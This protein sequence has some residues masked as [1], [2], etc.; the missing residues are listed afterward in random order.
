[1]MHLTFV[2]FIF[3]YV[4]AYGTMSRY[5]DQLFTESLKREPLLDLLDLAWD[6]R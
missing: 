2:L 6:R 5:V 1:M 3:S 4:L